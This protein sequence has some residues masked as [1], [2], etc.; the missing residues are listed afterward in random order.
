MN[1]TG[2]IHKR[3]NAVLILAVIFTFC[4]C[5]IGTERADAA[6][7]KTHLQETKIVLLEGQKLT[8]KLISSSGKTI[9]ASKVKWSSSAKSVAKVNSKGVVTAVKDG[10]ATITA[11]YN[12]KKYT[13]KVYVYDEMQADYAE[14]YGA[15]QAEHKEQ[16]LTDVSSID[17]TKYQPAD[18]SDKDLI[19]D[20]EV[21]TLLDR[22][23]KT[24]YKISSEAA[25]ED[26]GL[27]FRALK[28]SY[29]AYYYFGE[30]NFKKA[31]A[32]LVKWVSARDSMDK[33][34]F[35]G[36]ICEELDFMRDSYAYA[37][38]ENTTSR[39]FKHEYFSCTNQQFAKDQKG[40]YKTAKNKKWYFQ[41]FSDSRVTMEPV[42]T[43]DGTLTY[44]P[45]LL[46]PDAEKKSCKIVLKD[47][48]G[49][50]RTETI[51][52]NRNKG[53]ASGGMTHPC[54]VYAEEEGVAY[55]AVRNFWGDYSEEL[56]KFVSSG[57][58]AS[59]AETLILDIRS[60]G[61]G[62]SAYAYEFLKN[63]TGNIPQ[64]PSVQMKRESKLHKQESSTGFSRGAFVENDT[65]IIVLTDHWVESSGENFVMLSRACDNVMVIGSNTAGS[66][67]SG[68]ITH[69]V[70][71]NS[72]IK[73]GCPGMMQFAYEEK[74]MDGMGLM[75]DIWCSPK[76]ALDYTFKLLEAG[77]Q[78][79][80]EAVD[81]L[82]ESIKKQEDSFAGKVVSEGCTVDMTDFYS[83]DSKYI[84]IKDGGKVVLK[85]KPEVD[86]SKKLGG[87]ILQISQ[88][89]EIKPSDRVFRLDAAYGY[90]RK[91][92][93]VKAGTTYYVRV[94]PYYIVDGRNRDGLMTE[95]KSFTAS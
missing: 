59:R 2:Y 51:S 67:L 14:I 54:F 23:K 5:M 30:E 3:I 75:P 92:D 94:C 27:L 55:V 79:S 28:S 58:D 93:M 20:A 86:T 35:R 17:M 41:S 6:T 70:L 65:T 68:N 29:G 63:L 38:N 56:K 16:T 46:C 1:K 81:K 87:V 76:D 82:K 73:V 88:N 8:E 49:N 10:T 19:T 40:F 32:N 4:F 61:G 45:V 12:S 77:G 26:I 78:V 95:T 90:E 31:E 24:V 33:E 25:L 44:A 39:E 9:S 50:K 48:K 84:Y 7:K 85:L 22:P 91:L 11:T 71:P 37:G 69:M 53:Y 52:W 72:I 64:Y 15:A 18:A 80:E 89:A 34:V 36:K 42:L 47:S 13:A 60:N 66:L 43:E 21:K 74:N 57:K 83:G 62:S